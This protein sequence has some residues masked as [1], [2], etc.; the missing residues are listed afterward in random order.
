MIRLEDVHFAYP[1]GV[2]ALRG[3]S[4]ELSEGCACVIGQNGAGKTTLIKH[5]NGLYRPT[6]GRVTVGGQ[7]TRDRRVAQLARHV[8]LAF[9]NPDDQ[10][11]HPTVEEEVRFGPRNLGHA[12]A[13]VDRLAGWAMGLLGLEGVSAK[14]PYEVEFSWRKRVAIA[15]VIAMDTHVVVLDEPT[16]G[17]DAPGVGVLGEVVEELTRR[18]KLV[19]VV[20]HDIEFARVH[21]D[22]VIALYQ[23]SVLLDDDSRSVFGQPAELRRTYVRPPGVTEVGQLLKLERTVLSVDEL[24]A[25]L[26]LETAPPTAS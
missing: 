8:G 14:R 4:L 16:G 11:F 6:S 23:G 25:V 1:G 5:F 7:D 3:I 15:S 10:L 20:T 22:R 12:S 21:A 13:D 24:F 19:V 2:E 17:Q 26:G 9:Q 18:G